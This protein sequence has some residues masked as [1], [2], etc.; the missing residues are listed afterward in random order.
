MRLCLSYVAKIL[1]YN[2]LFA[3]NRVARK[4]TITKRGKSLIPW[5]DILTKSGSFNYFSFRNSEHFMGLKQKA[6]KEQHN[7]NIVWKV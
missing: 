6:H 4:Y 5:L 3:D 2:E 7:I 1:V